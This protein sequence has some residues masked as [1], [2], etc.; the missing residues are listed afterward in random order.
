MPTTPQKAAG[1]L[2]LAAESDPLDRG[3]MF[4][5]SDAPAPPEEPPE[6]RS[7]LKG[8]VVAPKTRFV[9]LEPTANSGEL[10]LPRTMPP[11]ARIRETTGSSAVGTLSLN[12]G[13]Q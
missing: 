2:I 10:V 12:K 3:A 8:L 9:V 13:E 6:V 1:F 4:V 11:A 5:A 7:V